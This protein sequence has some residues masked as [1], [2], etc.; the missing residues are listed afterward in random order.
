MGILLIALPRKYALIPIFLS[1]LYMT[2]GQRLVVMDLN[3]MIFRILI[4]IGF[5]RIIIRRDGGPIQYNTLEK[6]IILWGIVA[7]ITGFLLDIN[8]NQFDNLQHRSGQVFSA[9]GT[10]YIF[11]YYITSIDDIK[12]NIGILAIII[13]PLAVAFLIEKTSG[14]NLFFFFGG[15]PEFTMM[16]YDRLRCQGPF[17][18]PIL[19][20]TLGVTTMPMFVTLLFE[21]GRKKFIGLMGIISSIIIVI[22]SASSGPL[23]A[24]IGA[25]IA[26]F[27]WPLRNK[28][29]MV[30]WG[31]LLVLIALHMIMKAP[32][33]YLI[34]KISYIMGGTGW[35]R[36]ALID[37]AIK[38]FNEWWLIGTTNT[39]HWDPVGVLPNEAMMDITNQYILEGVYGGLAR[40]LL[41]IAMIV[42]GFGGI[43]KAMEALKNEKFAIKYLPWALGAALLAHAIGFISVAYFDQLIVMWYLLLAMISTISNIPNPVPVK[44]A[45][46]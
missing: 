39:A 44:K 5:L 34:A 26:L 8:T 25:M 19:A 41:F 36:S 16:R 46:A 6:V 37:Y 18:H 45:A 20:G 30:R 9:L 17:A 12:R 32:V 35:G 42:V 7:I 28:M 29:R 24:W 31:I 23:L 3:F 14:Q 22:T 11:R 4:V 2:L 15:V 33:W 1:A 43:G 40:M 38:Y 10:Y 13:V 27:S 21:Q